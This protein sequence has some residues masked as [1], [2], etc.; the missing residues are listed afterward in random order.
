MKK[1]KRR[2]KK[3]RVMKVSNDEVM[4]VHPK[5]H[6]FDRAFAWVED[7][8]IMLAAGITITLV[9]TVCIGLLLFA[10]GYLN[11]DLTALTI[12]EPTPF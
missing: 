6:W 12:V 3:V 5:E 4:Q 2:V 11:G 10:G 1:P 7:H 8:G 9:L